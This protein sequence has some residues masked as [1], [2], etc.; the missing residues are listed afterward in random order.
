MNENCRFIS[1]WNGGSIEIDTGAHFDPE[2]GIVSRI[3][4]ADIPDCII[5]DLEILDKEYIEF[6]GKRYDVEALDDGTYKVLDV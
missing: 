3:K 5:E 6:N 4:I 2:T 1:V